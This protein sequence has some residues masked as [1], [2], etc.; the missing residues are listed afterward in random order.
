M[1]DVFIG[2]KEAAEFEGVKYNTLV[3][4]IKRSPNQ[5]KTRTQPQENG[6]REQ[7]LVSV[8]SLTAKGRK[9]WRAAQKIDGRDVVI[10]K[11]TES[12]PWYVGVDLNHYTEQHKKAFY[13][14]VELAARVQDF[15]DYDGPDRTAYAE[16]YALGLGVSLPTLYRYVDNIL[17]ANAWALKMEKEDGQSRD[18][19]RALSLCRKPKATA[20]FPSLTDEQKALIQNI[21]FDR[22]FAANLGTIEMLRDVKHTVTDGL[23]GFATATGDGKSLKIGVS[24][25]VSDTPIII[26]G[27]MDATKIKDRLGL[28]PL[29]DAVMDS[30]QFGASRIYCL[31]VSATTAGELGIV[32]KTGDGGGSV[33]VDGSPTNAF[34]VVVKFTAQGQLNTAAF[35]YSIDGGNTFTDEITVPVNGEYEITGTGLKLKFTEATEEDQKPSSFLV[36][37]SYSFTTTAPT[38]TN[39]DVLAA[40]KKLQK[41]AE[42]YEFIHIVGE[43]DLD[44]WQAV[45]EA[46]IELRDVYHKPVFVVFEAKYPTTGDEEDEPDMMGGGDLTDWALEMEAKRKKVKNYDIQVVTAWGRLVKLDGS[47]QITNLAGLVCGLY[48]KAAVQ[49]SIGKTRTEAGFGIPKT[50]LLELLPAEMD[51]SII[52]LLDLAGYL[53]FREYDGLD[54]F[55]V[56]HTKMM[57]PDGSDLYDGRRRKPCRRQSHRSG[58]RK[59]GGASPARLTTRPIR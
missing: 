20:T 37:D 45:S 4:R 39:G 44:L 43:S 55:Y 30:V 19:F 9:A 21:W 3:R 40:F 27:D 15:I 59:S 51:N 56:Y 58:L 54:D 47:T 25:I 5:Y 57:S 2:L 53:T 11:R 16:R 17:K 1:P 22:R 6:G 41:F 13:E 28:S 34:S 14:A 23:L 10:E 24:P 8:D 31:P 36:N 26:T 48:A 35:V 32:S 7:V 52:E 33:T 50:K 46:Q 49:E 18:Y 38:M 42:E 12:A 29:A